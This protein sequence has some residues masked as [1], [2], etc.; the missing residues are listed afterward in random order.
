ML[1]CTREN[2]S[3]SI[4]WR[5]IEGRTGPPAGE[6][7]GVALAEGGLNGRKGHPSE[8]RWRRAEGFG[9]KVRKKANPCRAE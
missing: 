8:V 1:L 4:Q 6:E 2:S 9:W 3:I 5:E 7:R